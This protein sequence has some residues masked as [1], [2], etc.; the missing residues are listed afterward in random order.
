MKKQQNTQAIYIFFQFV[1][2]TFFERV[3]ARPLHSAHA[4]TRD[5]LNIYKESFNF[6]TLILIINIP[7]EVWI[8]DNIF[9]NN[10]ALYECT[11]RC[12]TYSVTAHPEDG[13]ARPKYVGATN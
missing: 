13:Q 5:I 8:V 12:T 3:P 7:Q 2:P 4:S 10:Y 1:A 9:M 11:H 6:L